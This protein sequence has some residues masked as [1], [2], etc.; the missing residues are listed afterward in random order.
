[1]IKEIWKPVVGYEDCYEIS[2][3]GR[4]LSLKRQHTTALGL[5]TYGGGYLKPTLQKGRYL[6]VNLSKDGKKRC[7]RVH[8]LMLMTFVGQ[9]P[10]DY[11]ACHNNGIPTDNRL[12]NLRWDTRKNNLAD[13]KKHGTDPTGERGSKAKLTWNQVINIKR[14]EKS[15]YRLAKDYGVG[16][17]TI[18]D[19][20]KNRT[21]KSE[22]VPQAKRTKR[23][24]SW[25]NW[26]QTGRGW[27]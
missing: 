10:K 18:S 8:R 25:D 23:E 20:K 24:A 7:Y 11:D 22:K 26:L 16:W 5:R 19:I 4:V 1:M 13:R 6:A 2:D 14:S 3:Q 21:W 27:D 15:I 12:E 17:T 9:P